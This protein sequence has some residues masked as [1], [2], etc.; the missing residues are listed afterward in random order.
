MTF[1]TGSCLKQRW[2]VIILV[3]RRCAGIAW[4]A[5]YKGLG[6][7]RRKWR[8]RVTHH[9]SKS[10]IFNNVDVINS[11]KIRPEHVDVGTDDATDPGAQGGGAHAHVPHHRGEELRGEDVDRPVGRGDC[12]LSKHGERHQQGNMF[13]SEFWLNIWQENFWQRY[14]WDENGEGEAKASKEHTARESS[15]SS[16]LW[17]VQ[18][19]QIEC[20]RRDLNSSTEE[21]VDA[22]QMKATPTQSGWCLGNERTLWGSCSTGCRQG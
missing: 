7:K 15:L 4:I 10:W 20:I 21:S 11:F 8:T 18:H 14:L 9:T 22:D 3:H 17:V 2:E 12:K 1:S 19:N 6:Y 5:R 16:D 13:L